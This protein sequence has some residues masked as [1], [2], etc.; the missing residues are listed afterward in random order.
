LSA[1]ESIQLGLGANTGNPG[2]RGIVRKAI[3]IL[4]LAKACITQMDSSAERRRTTG[5]DFLRV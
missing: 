3:E 2:Q 1:R 5:R 4:V